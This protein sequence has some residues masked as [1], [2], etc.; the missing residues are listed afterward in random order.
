[1]LTEIKNVRQIA[2]EARRR[3][4]A[5]E[6]MD[7]IVWHDGQR[8][9]SFQLCYDKKAEEK[10]LSWKP[11]TGLL[12]EQVDNGESGGGRYKATPVLLAAGDYNLERIKTDFIKHSAGIDETIKALVLQ[13]LENN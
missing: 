3:W 12:H 2:G 5:D 11:L 1:V 6:S 13:G 8:P 9:V 4:F 7:L 10:A